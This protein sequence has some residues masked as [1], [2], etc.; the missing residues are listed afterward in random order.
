MLSP[1][2]T[3]KAVVRIRRLLELAGAAALGAAAVHALLALA[4][5]WPRAPWLDTATANVVLGVF[6]TL[7]VL[8]GVRWLYSDENAARRVASQ[9][10]RPAPWLSPLVRASGESVVAALV[11]GVVVGLQGAGSGSDAAV[12]AYY[13]ALVVLASV[14]AIAARRRP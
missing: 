5:G 11:A 12:R 13:V 9:H 10:T 1:D 6:S 14:R 7:A 3:L 2:A 4:R 8:Y